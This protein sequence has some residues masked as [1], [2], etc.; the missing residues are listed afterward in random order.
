MVKTVDMKTFNKHYRMWLNDCLEQYN[1]Q[2]H[3]RS[4]HQETVPEDYDPG[5]FV[6]FAEDGDAYPHGLG[7]T[8]H[9]PHA[10]TSWEN[11]EYYVV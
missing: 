8:N 3:P 5:D 7:G 6:E 4:Y 9:I 2:Y 1:E 10:V 11:S